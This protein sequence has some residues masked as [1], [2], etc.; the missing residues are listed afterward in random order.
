MEV[1][2]AKHGKR[3][4]TTL[5]GR[6]LILV[7]MPALAGAAVGFALL[8]FNSSEDGRSTDGANWD[9]R[10]ITTP[11]QGYAEAVARAA[12]AVVNIF[13]SRVAKHPLCQLP[14]YRVLCERF[15]NRGRRVQGALGSGVMVRRDGY[16]L[17][18][19]HV[20]ADSQDI[21]VAFNDGRQ[22]QA[23]VVGTDAE[24]DLAVIQVEGDGFPA[25]AL[26]SS[27]DIEVGDLVLAIG[28]PFGIGQAVSQGIV[29]ARGRYGISP[30]P[31]DDFIQTDAAINPG[32]SGGALVDAHGRLVG[33]NTMIYSQGGGSE[34]IG[35]AI[36][37]DRAIKV[38]DAIVEHG[39]VLRGWLGVR[40]AKPLGSNARGLMVRSVVA[41]APAHSAGLRSGDLLL[42]INGEAV[43]S[44][45]AV[46]RQIANTEPNAKLSLR[47]WRN[48]AIRVV[49][50][51]AGVS[52]NLR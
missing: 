9:E 12:P 22:A 38:L 14:Q 28:N 43:S 8:W 33:I 30:N 25:I 27:K 45:A 3:S 17:T 51:I 20:I 16:I 4:W 2:S 15:L 5:T 44:L 39:R 21:I 31:D 47:I 42:A 35:F 11:S 26:A 48:G 1:P 34:G 19:Y 36:P 18:N 29:S 32:N 13:T 7:V 40:L 52:A 49:E 50:A 24:T 46:R 37:V 23:A 41:G 6:S 10:S